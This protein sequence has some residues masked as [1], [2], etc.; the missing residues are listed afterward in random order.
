MFHNRPRIDYIV[1]LMDTKLMPK[2]REDL[3]Q[4]RDGVRLPTWWKYFMREWKKFQGTKVQGTYLTCK[5]QWHCTCSAFYQSRFLLCKHLVDG[6]APLEYRDVVRSRFAPF[7]SVK[8]EYGRRHA[9]F[10]GDILPEIDLEEKCVL[11]DSAE[12][13]NIDGLQLE[14]SLCSNV[15]MTSSI[16]A[17]SK[18]I[19]DTAEW[20]I[21]YVQKLKQ[22]EAGGKKVEYF[23]NNV[24]GHL[25]K[26]KEDVEKNHATRTMPT[27]W[28]NRNTLYE[29]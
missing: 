9:L 28:G 29:P 16:E 25:F 17:N 20:L 6:Q 15:D 3:Q 5:R 19:V 12:Q 13:T 18:H 24:M 14:D 8:R 1:N 27:T 7:L 22:T 26:F 10:D 4:F 21:E 2:F 23:H 11:H